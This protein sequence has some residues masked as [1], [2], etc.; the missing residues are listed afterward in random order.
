MG[1]AKKWAKVVPASEAPSEEQIPSR[2]IRIIRNIHDQ[3]S[4]KDNSANIANIASK[5]STPGGQALAYLDQAELDRF[6]AMAV[7]YQ[8][9]DGTTGWID[10]A[11]LAD[12]QR[13]SKGGPQWL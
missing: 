11:Y 2:N 1:F 10:P 7:E 3:D 4:K 12:L 8:F 13:K 6:F 5:G 9:P